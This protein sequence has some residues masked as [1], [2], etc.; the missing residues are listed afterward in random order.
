[1]AELM[2]GTGFAPVL[3]PSQHAPTWIPVEVPDAAVVAV[4]CPTA[5]SCVA[6]GSYHEAGGHLRGL[7][8][9]LWKGTWT[10][11]LAPLPAGA[12]VN[13]GDSS[14]SNVACHGPG[15]CVAVGWETSANGDAH[16]HLET[17]SGGRWA[18]TQAPLPAKVPS[19]S[20]ASLTAVACPALRFCVAVGSYFDAQPSALGLVDTFSA[21]R[22]TASP[23]PPPPP[24]ANAAPEVFLQTVTCP[25]TDACVAIGSYVDTN[26]NIPGLIET[27]ARGTWIPTA[28]PRAAV[29]AVTCPAPGSCVAVG[30]TYG[31]TGRLHGLIDTLS[32]GTWSARQAPLPESGATDRSPVLDAV[33][34]PAV[35][36][37]VAIGAYTNTRLGH[38]DLIDVLHG[39]MWTPARVPLPGEGGAHH[40]A[41]TCPTPASCVAVGSYLDTGGTALHGL[42]ETLSGATW[43]TWRAPL[44]PNAEGQNPDASFDAMT[45]PTLGTCV[46]VGWYRDAT[47]ATQ[48][49]IETPTHGNSSDL[50]M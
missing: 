33:T 40:D 42:V 20:A 22:W 3:S 25:A 7:L 9:T 38:D 32:R 6:V 36:S 43:T 1:M 31:K 44:P 12:T 14:L 21:G 16:G 19:T 29:F 47:G 27:L 15:F 39:S 26:R 18:P 50:S 5:S 17:L 45:C 49:L 13:R 48:G 10:A 37:C 24:N 46:A 28:V 34:C 2:V 11:V 30:S 41:L 8:A 4:T 35:G 23:P